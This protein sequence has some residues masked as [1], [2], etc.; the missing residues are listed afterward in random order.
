[1]SNNPV[2]LRPIERSDLKFLCD[3]SNSPEVRA[4]VVGWDW[5]LSLANQEKWFDQG[6]DS[7]TTRRLIIEN[8]SGK[9]VG[10]TGLWDID[11]HN[12]SALTAIKLGG[13]PAERPR[14]LAVNAISALMEF[15]FMDVGLNRLHGSMLSSNLPSFTLFVNKCG[16]VKEGVSRK[17]VWRN[18]DFQDVTQVGILR[19][20]YLLWVNKQS[21]PVNIS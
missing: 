14:G 15:A 1:M 9:A 11:W 12:R 2:I 3:L 5:P 18:G 21:S 20:E 19:D 13:A 7:S 17:H 10:L 6:Q 8:G 16:W 4:N